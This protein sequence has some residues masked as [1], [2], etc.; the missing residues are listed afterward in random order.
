MKYCILACIITLGI[1]KTVRFLCLTLC[2][3]SIIK[4]PKAFERFIGEVYKNESWTE[5][6]K[7]RKEI[8]PVPI[9]LQRSS[10]PQVNCSKSTG[11]GNQRNL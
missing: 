11:L 3:K 2:L 10:E 4:D 5:K 1:Y 9:C 8:R 7:A 6:G